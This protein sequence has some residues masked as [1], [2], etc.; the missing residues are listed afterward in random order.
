[1]KFTGIIAAGVAALALTTVAAEAFDIGQ[2]GVSVGTELDTFWDTDGSQF[3]S[4][5]TPK[6]GYNALGIDLSLET[7]LDIV[8]DGQV[9]AQD[10]MFSFDTRPVVTLGAGYTIGTA[11]KARAYGEVDIDTDGFDTAQGKVG[12]ILSF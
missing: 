6:V 5:L 10:T 9:V 4:V 2:T 11:F 8:K 12:M 7:D 1:M 3:Q